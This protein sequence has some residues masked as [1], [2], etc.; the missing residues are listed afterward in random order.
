[1][2]LFLLQ[3]RDM[4]ASFIAIKMMSLALLSRHTFWDKSL[5][6]GGWVVIKLA[7]SFLSLAVFFHSHVVRTWKW[8]YSCLSV[9]WWHHVYIVLSDNHRVL[10]DVESVRQE[11][12]LL[13]EQMQIVKEDIKKVSFNS[14]LPSS[15]SSCSAFH[16]FQCMCILTGENS[17]P[18]LRRKLI[19]ILEDMR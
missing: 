7:P 18:Y 19:P 4:M 11:A 8:N 17:F 6:V 5:V 2:R 1:M 12:T 14:D 16:H 13:R 10:R 3:R 9:W 15:S